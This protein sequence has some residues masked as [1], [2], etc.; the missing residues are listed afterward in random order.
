MLIFHNRKWGA[1]QVSLPCMIIMTIEHAVKFLALPNENYWRVLHYFYC[2]LCELAPMSTTEKF[3]IIFHLT[4]IMNF[5]LCCYLLV[6]NKWWI[7]HLSFM[8]S[9][10]VVWNWLCR[11]VIN[12]MLASCWLGTCG[13]TLVSVSL[14]FCCIVGVGGCFVVRMQDA[15][16]FLWEHDF[17]DV[18]ALDLRWFSALDLYAKIFWLSLHWI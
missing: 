5:Y 4:F 10:C 8:M 11:R 6:L 2:E 13:C 3:C 12:V 14:G 18:A 1:P 9:S 16:L 7:C 17:L 15:I